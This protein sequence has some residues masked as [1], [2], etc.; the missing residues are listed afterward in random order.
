MVLDQMINNSN[1]DLNVGQ[2][3]AN[4]VSTMG[5]NAD[6][7]GFSISDVNA[8]ITG[9]KAGLTLP[10]IEEYMVVNEADAASFLNTLDPESFDGSEE[11]VYSMFFE[12]SSMTETQRKYF[13]YDYYTLDRDNMSNKVIKL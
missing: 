11:I 13:K 5:L 2:D 10:F 8:Y 9:E 6:V 4:E 3:I 1:I 12:S 7:A